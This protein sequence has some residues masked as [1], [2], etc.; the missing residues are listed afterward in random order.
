MAN[1]PG[2]QLS[3]GNG[4]TLN[5]DAARHFLALVAEIFD[6]TGIVILATEGTRTFARQSTLYT[7]WV[8]RLPGYNPAWPPNSPFAYH[9]SGRAVDV[10][11]GVGYRVTLASQ[12]FYERAGKYGFRASIAGEPW[13]FEWRAEWVQTPVTPAAPAPTPYPSEE[14]DDMI[15]ILFL[16]SADGRRGIVGS[17]YSRIFPDQKEQDFTL[18][19]L[20]SDAVKGRVRVTDVDVSRVEFDRQFW[21]VTTPTDDASKGAISKI[22]TK[23]GIYK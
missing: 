9:L 2:A 13:H 16:K 6:E 20:K 21:A 15:D 5:A 3:I 8:A 1:T 11:S 19:P 17:G 14:D 4:Q 22:A 12:A 18:R 7:G 10:G 23:L